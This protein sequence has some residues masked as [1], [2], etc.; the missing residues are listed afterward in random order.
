[1]ASH[2]VV[3]AGLQ[4]S[5]IIRERSSAR[6]TMIVPFRG[7]YYEMDSNTRLVNTMIY[8]VPD[9]RLPFLGVHLT[10]AIDGGVHVG[11]NA[12]PALATEGYR[13]RD[14][15][16]PYVRELVAYP[17]ARRLAR[18]YWRT[19]LQEVHR[20]LSKRAFVH[21]VQR[22]VPDI[23]EDMLKP[24]APGVRAQAV[25]NDGALVDDFVFQR[26]D[27][28]IRVVNAP[29]PAATAALAIGKHVAGML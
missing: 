18:R 26:S 2:A 21:E 25:R 20:S 1:V 14:V 8:P 11:P 17:G 4:S 3:C 7:E 22:L 6:E 5:R 9:P 27:H 15:H 12:V 28:V 13:W 24:S 19:G 23:T 10:R 16:W 29:S